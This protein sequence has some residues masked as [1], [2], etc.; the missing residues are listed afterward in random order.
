MELE[1]LLPDILAAQVFLLA[2]AGAGAGGAAAEGCG[3]TPRLE[4]RPAT[5]D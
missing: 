1:L 5:G 2:G 4:P 3:V